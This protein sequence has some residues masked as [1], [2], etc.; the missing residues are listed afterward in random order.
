MLVVLSG[1]KQWQIQD[2]PKGADHGECEPIVGLG[3]QW[4]SPWWGIRLLMQKGF[5]NFHTRRGQNNIRYLPA[6]LRQTAS[7]I[8]VQPLLLVSGDWLLVLPM[9]GSPSDW[10]W[11][12]GSRITQLLDHASPILVSSWSR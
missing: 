10:S 9:P 7:C 6:C 1:W 2:L 3:V 5:V 4:Q 11:K 12:V 8:H